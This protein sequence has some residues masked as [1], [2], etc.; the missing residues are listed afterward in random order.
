MF[1]KFFM[2]YS[3]STYAVLMQYTSWMSLQGVPLD[4]VLEG[5]HQAIDR[6]VQQL[7]CTKIAVGDILSSRE[8]R[9]RSCTGDGN[10]GDI[11]DS[12]C[13]R[14]NIDNSGRMLD[15]SSCDR[16]HSDNSGRMLDDSSC[17]R[18]H[19]DNSGRMLDDSSCDRLHSDNSGRMLD[20]SSC[21]RLHSDN[22]GRM[23][24]DNLCNSLHDHQS[25]HAETSNAASKNVKPTILPQSHNDIGDDDDDISWYFDDLNL[26]SPDD[27]ALEMLMNTMGG[28][29][30]KLGCFTD[31]DT[32]SCRDRSGH[33]V[34]CDQSGDISPTV[35]SGVPI[36]G[37]TSSIGGDKGMQP[38]TLSPQEEKTKCQRNQTS[39]DES[40][41]SDKQAKLLS[42]MEELSQTSKLLVKCNQAI[43]SHAGPSVSSA[44][45]SN[46]DRSS[47]IHPIA[48][49]ILD[50]NNGSISNCDTD[51]VVGS[52][53]RSLIHNA[54]NMNPNLKSDIDSSR[55]A[56]CESGVS[57]GFICNANVSSKYDGSS[58][59]RKNGSKFTSDSTRT[60]SVSAHPEDSD[61]EFSSCF[62]DVEI[63]AENA[64][65][66]KQ[67]G[68]AV[69]PPCD[70]NGVQSA[71]SDML[72]GSRHFRS[73]QSL[74]RVS[75]TQESCC[76]TT[77]ETICLKSSRHLRNTNNN[78]APLEDRTLHT[79]SPSEVVTITTS[80]CHCNAKTES[81]GS[82][83]HGNLDDTT[84]GDT[85]AKSHVDTISTE[86]SWDD[87]P[88]KISSFIHCLGQ[89][90]EDI[91][92][93][94]TETMLRQLKSDQL[95]PDEN[96]R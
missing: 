32:T 79:M 90:C 21:D 93:A 52:N 84:L 64:K 14:L 45:D 80:G 62:D 89:G 57:C 8:P 40:L 68:E 76:S 48:G 19:S 74:C 43:S 35:S 3:C 24:V 5:F 2:Q 91:L 70:Q 71:D 9:Q 30:Q 50:S 31:D 65:R 36:L 16:L 81:D 83:I 37:T 25:E 88:R 66:K 95:K 44:T 15:D 47:N 69:L 51:S 23:L 63:H 55:S 58:R 54:D 10:S 87:H 4:A 85:P 12:S 29:Q 18:L 60:T 6:C 27:D 39:T 59:A 22:S 72:N 46:A 56:E 7:Q 28:M 49:S 61:D 41:V 94:V 86:E 67:F 53:S 82:D 73:F 33:V 13:D 96:L 17:D 34:S 42:I 75:S 38:D 78:H 1:V 11:L 26:N 77:S 20:D 92:D